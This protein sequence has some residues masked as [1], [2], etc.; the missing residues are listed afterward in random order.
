MK[1]QSVEDSVLLELSANTYNN[2]PLHAIFRDAVDNFVNHKAT[3]VDFN[4]VDK[5]RCF[6][7]YGGDDVTYLHLIGDSDATKF[8]TSSI[9]YSNADELLLSFG[10]RNQHEQV[11]NSIFS[12][13]NVL[14]LFALGNNVMTLIVLVD[15]Y[16]MHGTIILFCVPR[17]ER[18]QS[19]FEKHA[20]V[21]HSFKICVD[22][23]GAYY[24]T[25][26]DEDSSEQ[27]DQTNNFNL[28]A[29]ESPCYDGSSQ[30]AAKASLVSH[31]QGV[32]Y[33]TKQARDTGGNPHA[34]SFAYFGKHV[35]EMTYSQAGDDILHT[36]AK[37]EV[38]SAH[39]VFQNYFSTLET[40]IVDELYSTQASGK[41]V[42]VVIRNPADPSIAS[43]LRKPQPL[44]DTD[45]LAIARR[46]ISAKESTTNV[47]SCDMV[48][49]EDDLRKN[50]T[51]GSDRFICQR[52]AN[53]ETLPVG[54]EVTFLPFKHRKEPFSAR[55]DNHGTRIMHDKLEPSFDHT[56]AREIDRNIR[57]TKFSD[58]SYMRTFINPFMK[59]V[60]IPNL[61]DDASLGA[62]E[63]EFAK[64]V[65]VHP[66]V[67]WTAVCASCG[68]KSTYYPAIGGTAR[69]L[70]CYCIGE[71]V[72]VQSQFGA[73]VPTL[74]KRR[75]K[76]WNPKI[77]TALVGQAIVKSMKAIPLFASRVAECNAD[78]KLF[79][80]RVQFEYKYVLPKARDGP[81]MDL[82]VY[83][84][85]DP[86]ADPP[87]DL[88]ALDAE[89]TKRKQA[90]EK[91]KE[92][93][94]RNASDA[95]S[96]VRDVYSKLLNGAGFYGVNLVTET[97]PVLCTLAKKLLSS[98]NAFSKYKRDPAKVTSACFHTTFAIHQ[99]AE[100]A[101]HDSN[102]SCDE[103]KIL[104]FLAAKTNE[105]GLGASFATKLTLCSCGGIAGVV[106]IDDEDFIPPKRQCKS[107]P[108]ARS[109]TPTFY[110]LSPEQHHWR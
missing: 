42:A 96:V 105:A 4:L 2:N 13:G 6:K 102:L 26:H 18:E 51:K 62:I 19:E 39:R 94:T 58:K 85:A 64:L 36:S 108:S 12:T 32:I 83:H 41:N 15:L 66:R 5:D 30:A 106:S 100:S 48:A 57:E 60:T 52:L 73:F 40:P 25:F 16:K 82:Q 23:E 33:Y 95:A 107:D 63:A 28:L 22:D 9:G 103:M 110:P 50:S 76:N 67:W 1:R 74:C 11:N 98:D 24:P 84:R 54:F 68:D 78:F 34:A 109:T 49:S 71:N 65:G 81:S 55:I 80:S 79:Q 91:S 47:V 3:R 97:H 14:T 86:P 90:C 35:D 56:M 27:G 37:G 104:I 89:Q 43:D 44:D 87:A 101:Y 92:T 70:L 53:S 8:V 61:G 88:A 17:V 29:R 77:V 21:A 69:A 31:V 99:L 75:L 59:F 72:I 20:K 10:R 38:T 45:K 46:H 7:S 93:R